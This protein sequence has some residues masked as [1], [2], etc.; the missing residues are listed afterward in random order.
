MRGLRNDRDRA[1][2]SI[3]LVHPRR[4]RALVDER[5]AEPEPRDAYLAGIRNRG[6]EPGVLAHDV[7][8]VGQ[9]LIDVL[10]SP[11][12]DWEGG[13]FASWLCTKPPRELGFDFRARLQYTVYV[14]SAMV[15][16]LRLIRR[17]VGALVI[18]AVP[19]Q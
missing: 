17:A 15:P 10:C 11:V 2:V 6:Q 14:W 1:K 9:P 16:G 18:I 19:L 7:A 13:Q 8:H 5:R 12:N 4:C 3:W